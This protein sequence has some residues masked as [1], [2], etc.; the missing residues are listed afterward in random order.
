MGY[1]K[2]WEDPLGPEGV[3]QQNSV[4][5]FFFLG[6]GGSVEHL[7]TYFGMCLSWT[8]LRAGRLAAMDWFDA[9]PV[10]Y[11]FQPMEEEWQ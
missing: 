4:I 6:S 9:Y 1:F 8:Y 5:L 10:W 11:A 7:E 2:H 3:G